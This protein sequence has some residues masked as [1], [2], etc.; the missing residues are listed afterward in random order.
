MRM[1]SGRVR[2]MF[3]LWSSKKIIYAI[4]F[5]CILQFYFYMSSRLYRKLNKQRFSRWLL[6]VR[7]RS[8]ND[9]SDTNSYYISQ[10]R[11]VLFSAAMNTVASPVFRFYIFK[12]II[13]FFMTIYHL[14]SDL[15]WICHFTSTYCVLKSNITNL[16]VVNWKILLCAAGQKLQ[17][18]GSENDRDE[19]IF[20]L[21]KSAIKINEITRRKC[22]TGPM[23]WRKIAFY[24]Y[25]DWWMISFQRAQHKGNA[26][27]RK[28]FIGLSHVFFHL[29]FFVPSIEWPFFFFFFSLSS[30]HFHRFSCIRF[31][32]FVATHTSLYNC[33]RHKTK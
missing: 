30:F 24:Y 19:D 16:I 7:Y 32:P 10:L 21:Q 2:C 9:A 22:K 23:V 20:V 15:R 5:S 18:C 12:L 29:R 1:C 3:I 11:V 4:G 26:T 31:S 25:I 14:W 8:M 17:D 13:L 28:Q 27:Q 33:H 6:T